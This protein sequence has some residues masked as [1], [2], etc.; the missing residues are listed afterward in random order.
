MKPLHHW[1]DIC[2]P[3]IHFPFADHKAVA[4][5]IRFV[6]SH[7]KKSGST[8]RRITQ[9]GDLRDQ[10][11]FG[12]FPRCPNVITPEQ[13]L[14]AG[15]KM[16]IKFWKDL[17]DAAPKAKCYQLMGNHDDR[18]IK[19]I[20]ELAPEYTSIVRDGMKALYTFD[21]V[22]T[23]GSQREELNFD[24]VVYTHGFKSNLGDHARYFQKSCVHGH[25]H[26]GGVIYIPLHDREIWEMDCG[27]LGQRSSPALSYTHTKRATTWT[28]G[29]GVI[30]P[31]GPR[32]I[33][34]Q[35]I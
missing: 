1:T 2:I 9:L 18:P 4:E 17:R 31:Y 23:M 34:L 33:S 26:K 27:H 7:K 13:E 35:G 32:F 10:F 15:S 28:T 29:F 25:T 5:V 20:T 30:D 3:D 21:G 16:S 14:A 24:D 11:S 19:R 8:I 22:K 6:R 12:R